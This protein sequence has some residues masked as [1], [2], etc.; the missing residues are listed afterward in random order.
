MLC[1]GVGVVGPG[2]GLLLLPSCFLP[3]A[4]GVAVATPVIVRIH[5]SS[6]HVVCGKPSS[7]LCVS[8]EC[9][10]YDGKF[11]KVARQQVV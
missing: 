10:D 3:A 9:T 6:R 1:L 7:H 2:V 4:P 5:P 11:D 8:H